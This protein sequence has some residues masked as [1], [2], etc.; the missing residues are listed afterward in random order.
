MSQVA[1]VTTQNEF[2][3][4][5][6]SENGGTKPPLKEFRNWQ[7]ARDNAKY[8]LLSFTTIGGDPEFSAHM[9]FKKSVPLIVRASWVLLVHRHINDESSDSPYWDAMHSLMKSDRDCQN[10][11]FFLQGFEKAQDLCKSKRLS[12]RDLLP[13]KLVTQAA[14]DGWNRVRAGKPFPTAKL[15]SE[16]LANPY[17]NKLHTL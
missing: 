13:P 9:D 6:M 7:Q 2:L 10:L 3:V 15:I 5:Y 11:L 16:H 17:I 4:A 12:H 8:K 1:H 14:C